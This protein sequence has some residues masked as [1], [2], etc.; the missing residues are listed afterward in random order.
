MLKGSTPRSTKVPLAVMG[1]LPS[2]M[3][4]CPHQRRLSDALSSRGRAPPSCPAHVSRP[5]C[6][7]Q[8]MRTL[9]AP[10]N[11]QGII[12]D[13][14]PG[15][16]LPPSDYKLMTAAI[17]EA[18]AAANL[19]P[20]PYFTLKVGWAIPLPPPCL[21][22]CIPPP[23]QPR[24][25]HPRMQPPPLKDGCKLSTRMRDVRHGTAALA[26][27]ASPCCALPL[28]LD[29]TVPCLFSFTVLCLAS[30]A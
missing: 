26:S 18:S 14:F 17:E 20:T 23:L 22:L 3:I 5:L 27:S 16:E 4:R 1:L 15:I 13:L 6:V 29:R 28:Q 8:T 11:A 2:V 30:S 12:S 7:P 21:V 10:N 24:H 25:V 9:R 19:Q